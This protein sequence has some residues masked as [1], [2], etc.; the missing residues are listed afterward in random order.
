MWQRNSLRLVAGVWSA[1]WRSPRVVIR[2]L[3]LRRKPFSTNGELSFGDS[4]V[5]LKSLR[6]FVTE[7]VKCRC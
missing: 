6:R 7:A 5:Y 1:Y 3:Q 4:V 2:S